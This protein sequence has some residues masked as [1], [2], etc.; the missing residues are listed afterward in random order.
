MDPNSSLTYFLT[1]YVCSTINDQVTAEK[2]LIKAIELYPDYREAVFALSN[3]YKVQKKIPEAE[4]II[5]KYSQNNPSDTSAVK[6]LNELK[7]SGNMK[8][9]TSKIK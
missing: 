5:G 8:Q 9:D 6:L 3:L 7:I 2:N 1:A 4:N